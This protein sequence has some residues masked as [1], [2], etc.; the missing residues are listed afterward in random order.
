MN[1]SNILRSLLVVFVLS[2]SV[3]MGFAQTTGPQGPAG[4]QGPVGPKGATGPQGPVGPQGAVGPRGATG[5]QGPVGPKGAT[6]ATGPQG[7]VG[8]AGSVTGGLNGW[9]INAGNYDASAFGLG[10]VTNALVISE[11]NFPYVGLGY[12]SNQ[13]G[14]LIN[15]GLTVKTALYV[16]NLVRSGGV[17]TRDINCNLISCNGLSAT[18]DIFCNSL[19]V[20][21]YVECGSLGVSNN[22]TIHGSMYVNGSVYGNS[23]NQTSDRNSKEHLRPIN[24]E[25]VLEKVVSMPISKWNYKSGD[26]S[27]HIGPTAQ[28]FYTKFGL[29][30]DDKHIATIDQGGVAFAAIKGLNQKLQKKLEE[31]DAKINSLEERLKSIESR[32]DTLQ[33]QK[34]SKF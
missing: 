5:P 17:E 7:P 4:P 24:D 31:K 25:N 3:P 6:G 18:N 30:S 11:Y 13:L 21:N 32:L 28:D 8:P 12:A 20:V 15:G 26:K 10:T 29:G 19:G 23:F 27:E 2:S 33:E 14:M 34:A 22:A 16:N 9:K 1:L